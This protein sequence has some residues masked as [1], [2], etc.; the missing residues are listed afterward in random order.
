M[1]VPGNTENE[2][3]VKRVI[4]YTCGIVLALAV[5]SGFQI[6]RAARTVDGRN[7]AQWLEFANAASQSVTFLAEGR[8]T[9]NGNE[10]TF[11]LE[12]GGQGR[13]SMVVS[14]TGRREC[15]LGM[16]GDQV[17]Y[18][19]GK[20]LARAIPPGQPAAPLRVR[21]RISGV[22]SAA[23][24]RAVHL[25]AESGMM[26]RELAIDRQTG[27][28]LAMSTSFQGRQLNRMVVDR[29]SFQPASAP[30][31]PVLSGTRCVGRDAPDIRDAL[32]GEI[33]RLLKRPALIPRQLPNGYALRR[34]FL[35][36]CEG[37]LKDM[38]VLRYTN[39]SQSL[40]L[41]EMP[42]AVTYAKQKGCPMAPDNADHVASRQLGDATVVAVGNVE[43]TVLADA[44]NSLI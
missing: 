26:L 25:Q 24:R 13:Y 19:T 40:T 42:G 11:T 35:Q 27:V 36:W 29:I 12:Q 4:L 32:P 5:V 21:E 1:D 7:A 18:R 43:P 8:T 37:C 34:T 20:Q 16:N 28:V 41:F 44:L 14:G 31:C 38:A 30:P 2:A 3:P 6:W 33:E 15:S 9:A 17:W 39:G 10:M 22:E 23:G